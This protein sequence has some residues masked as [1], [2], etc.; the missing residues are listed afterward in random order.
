MIYSI[1]T[2]GMVALSPTVR[3]LIIMITPADPSLWPA[4]HRMAG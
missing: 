1:S 3:A 2:P 4:A